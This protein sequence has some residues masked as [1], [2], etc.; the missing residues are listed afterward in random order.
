[1]INNNSTPYL[2]KKISTLLTLSAAAIVMLLLAGPLLP[3][4]N[5]LLLQPVQAQTTMTFRTPEGHPA[6]STQGGPEL[7]FDAQGTACSSPCEYGEITGGTFLFND[8]EYSRVVD[9]GNLSPGGPSLFAND[10]SGVKITL[11]YLGRSSSGGLSYTINTT[12]STSDDNSISIN[13]PGPEGGLWP[14]RTYNGAVEC[15]IAG[16]NTAAEPSSSSPSPSP[17]LTAGS[18]QG[19]DRGNGS[20]SSNSNSKDGDRDGVPDSSD[21]CTHNSNPKCFK[22]GVDTSSTTT[23]TTNQPQSSTTS[24]DRTGNQTR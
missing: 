7:I 17:S 15:T 9:S 5:I 14:Y 6:N 3:L 18:S 2:R 20:S 4:F 24:Y 13:L 22:E 10:S 11:T 16:G 8:T 21:R 1:L 12:C 19:T 23:T